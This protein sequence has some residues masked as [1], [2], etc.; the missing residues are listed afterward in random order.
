MIAGV[1][2]AIVSTQRQFLGLHRSFF[3]RPQPLSEPVLP[4]RGFIPQ[5]L[6]R[7]QSFTDANQPS[8]TGILLEN[9]VLAAKERREPLLSRLKPH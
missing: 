5:F 1:P 9:G 2:A 7:H 8:F 6:G 3:S 4:L